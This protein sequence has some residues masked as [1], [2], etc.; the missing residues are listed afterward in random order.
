LN[1]EYFVVC[2]VLLIEYKLTGDTALCCV[3]P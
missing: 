2:A 1:F 3:L